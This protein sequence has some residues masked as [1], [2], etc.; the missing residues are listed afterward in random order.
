MLSQT[1]Q[2]VLLDA[3]PLCRFAEC[4]LLDSLRDYLGARARIAREVE[5]ELLRRTEP[6]FADLLRHLAHTSEFVRSKGKWPKTTAPIPD[7]LKPAFINLLNLHR[8]V[9]G[10]ERAH[11]GEIATVLMAEQRAADLV[12]IDDGWGADLARPRGL[13]VMSTARLALEMVAAAL[14]LRTR[15]S[16]SSMQTHLTRLGGNGSSRP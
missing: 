10:H 9:C 11:A 8:S 16:R 3:S 2:L 14:F 5:R 7:S 15:A 12:V 4:G 1:A 6:E 13:S